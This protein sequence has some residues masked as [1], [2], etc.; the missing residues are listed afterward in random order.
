MK[1]L[2][3]T[4]TLAVHLRASVTVISHSAT[5]TLVALAAALIVPNFVPEILTLPH[6]NV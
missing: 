4:I 6:L 3:L 2:D 5:F 1:S